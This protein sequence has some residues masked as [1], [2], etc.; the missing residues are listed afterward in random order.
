[1]RYRSIPRAPSRG[2]LF[3]ARALAGDADA[4]MADV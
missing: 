1:M 2:V 3:L 4:E